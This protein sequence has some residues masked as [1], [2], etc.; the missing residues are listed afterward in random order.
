[1]KIQNLKK[2]LKIFITKTNLLKNSYYI[3]ENRFKNL[4][5]NTSNSFDRTELTRVGL[6]F[7]KLLLPLETNSY[8]SSLT[9]NK[10]DNLKALINYFTSLKK[11]ENIM[12]YVIKTKFLFFKRS[13]VFGLF[14]FLDFLVVHK[15]KFLINNTTR[16]HFLIKETSSN[17]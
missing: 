16:L 13:S 5:K 9:L 2:D 12:A 4:D 14:L 11:R 17:L 6:L 8:P 15:I 3:V 7:S 1:M 10:F